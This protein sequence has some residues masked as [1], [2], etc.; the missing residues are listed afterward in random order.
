M[1]NG[2][3]LN[4]LYASDEIDIPKKDFGDLLGLLRVTPLEFV[5]P[6]RSIHQHIL[7]GEER[8]GSI[9]NFQFDQGVIVSVFIFNGLAGLSG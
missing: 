2:L 9:R 5:D 6:S 3:F 7:A 1:I 8:M 4:T